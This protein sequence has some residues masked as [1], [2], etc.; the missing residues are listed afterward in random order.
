MLQTQLLLPQA[1]LGF[2]ARIPQT[3]ALL[4]PNGRPRTQLQPQL[5]LPAWN[6][7]G[8]S[9]PQASC[10]AA[11]CL[12]NKAF[13]ETP[14]GEPHNPLT[15][16]NFNHHTSL[17]CFAQTQPKKE[18]GGWDPRGVKWGQRQGLAQGGIRSCSSSSSKGHRV[19]TL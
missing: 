3:L 13:Q 19:P 14:P 11:D 9:R 1:R 8:H 5:L 2:M 10:A 17:S 16:W 18:A 6:L 15:L 12:A 7:S 4:P